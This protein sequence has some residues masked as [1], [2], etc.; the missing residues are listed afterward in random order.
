MA[1]NKTQS[2]Q[3]HSNEVFVVTFLPKKM[4]M[5]TVLHCYSVSSSLHC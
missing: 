4:F 2:G 1:E 5:T 3:I